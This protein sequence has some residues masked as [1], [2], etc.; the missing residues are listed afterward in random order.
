MHIVLIDIGKKAQ[1]V[2]DT[3]YDIGDI[4]TLKDNTMHVKTSRYRPQ[5]CDEI[6]ADGKY[7]FEHYWPV[8][9]SIKY[10]ITDISIS[11]AS[12]VLTYSLY[13]SNNGLIFPS[14]GCCVSIHEIEGKVSSDDYETDP[15]VEKWREEVK[16][17]LSTM[18]EAKEVK[19][20]PMYYFISDPNPENKSTGNR[21][22]R[23]SD[24]HLKQKDW[25]VMW[26]GGDA[27]RKPYILDRDWVV[28]H[29]FDAKSSNDHTE[30]MLISEK[31]IEKYIREHCMSKPLF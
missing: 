29:A 18:S 9:V 25:V 28:N 16:N 21:T 17:N 15:V 8:E 4:V 12:S 2:I 3:E 7:R 10:V 1:T 22:L 31:D 14:G 13:Y 30:F 5:I 11:A 6:E 19:E 27:V 26:S 20:D 23:K 24:W